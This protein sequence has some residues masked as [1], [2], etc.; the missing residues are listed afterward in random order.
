MGASGSDSEGGDF[1]LLEH[2]RRRGA[3]IRSRLRQVPVVLDGLLQRV[4]IGP[5]AQRRRQTDP[6]LDPDFT[7]R[8]S[9]RRPPRPRAP[10]SDRGGKHPQAVSWKPVAVAGSWEPEAGS[11]LPAGLAPFPHSVALV[12]EPTE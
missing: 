9:L 8:Q 1:D 2:R 10:D 4:R 3:R 7:R 12:V 11:W 6:G 5:A